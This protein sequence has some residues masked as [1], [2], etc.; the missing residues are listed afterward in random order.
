MLIEAIMIGILLVMFF[1]LICF[2]GYMI[3]I[4]M[5][6]HKA[7]LITKL[8]GNERVII[9]RAKTVTKDNITKWD[10]WKRSCVKKN[11]GK[12]TAPKGEY[13]KLDKKGNYNAIGYITDQDEVV[14][15]KSS[16]AGIEAILSEE[17]RTNYIHHLQNARDLKGSNLLQ[18]LLPIG[19]LFILAIVLVFG[20][21]MWKDIA[22]PAVNANR[23]QLE[24]AKEQTMQYEIMED[25]KND[26]QRIKTDVNNIKEKQDIK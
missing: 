7:Y 3:F 17:D 20:M 18:V 2:M 1:G 24:I 19:A 23:I 14:W 25:I 6:P 21:V 15:C 8:D 11:K 9:T 22:E 4:K 12:L 13:I 10:L 16:S 26:V 5:Y